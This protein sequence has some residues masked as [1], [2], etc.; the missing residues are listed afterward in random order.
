MKNV[1]PSITDRELDCAIRRLCHVI[2]FNIVIH[3]T[4]LF[5]TLTKPE[6]IETFRPWNGKLP[7]RAEE[8]IFALF[9]YWPVLVLASR[10]RASIRE[11]ANAKMVEIEK[12]ISDNY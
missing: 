2:G 3:L 12:E 7:P 5:L 1:K 6:L 10:I 4:L 8:T 11:R 9:L